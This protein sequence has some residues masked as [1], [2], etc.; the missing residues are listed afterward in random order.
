MVKLVRLIYF[1]HHYSLKLLPFS[2]RRLKM[3]FFMAD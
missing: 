1:I 2:Y 3:P